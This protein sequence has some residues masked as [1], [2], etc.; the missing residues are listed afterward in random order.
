MTKN[1]TLK[2]IYRK[3]HIG[4]EHNRI[5]FF[6]N[7]LTYK[8]S[9]KSLLNKT[10]RTTVNLLENIKVSSYHFAESKIAQKRAKI[11]FKKIHKKKSMAGM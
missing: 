5:Y 7:Y 11:I 6:N 9:I 8:S 2:Y 1:K 3:D 10:K 4:N